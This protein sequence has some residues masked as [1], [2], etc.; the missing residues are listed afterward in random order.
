MC[1]LQRL[2]GKSSPWQVLFVLA[3][4]DLAVFLMPRCFMDTFL[5]VVEELFRNE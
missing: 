4:P 2:R 3:N 5:L 1:E